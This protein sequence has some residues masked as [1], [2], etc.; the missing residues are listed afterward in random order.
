MEEIFF[1]SDTHFGNDLPLKR[2][3]RPF[4]NW[5]SFLVKTTKIWNKQTG[6][7]NHLSFRRLCRLC[8]K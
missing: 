1:T 5:K 4:E 7:G 8:S 2:E 6:K 3:Y